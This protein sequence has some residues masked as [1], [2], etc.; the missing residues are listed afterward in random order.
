MNQRFW[1][2]VDKSDKSD[3]C[4]VWTGAPRTDGYGQFRLDGKIIRPHRFSYTVKFGA[5]PD[6]LFVCHSCDNRL[7]VNPDHLFLGTDSDNKADM[8]AK[9]RHV[10]GENHPNKKL[11]KEIV[12]AIR[13]KIA[14]GVPQ[15]KIA[16]MFQTQRSQV[17]L[18]NSGKRWASV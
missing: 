17:S 5:I 4:W 8:Y 10:F 9:K 16:E 7:C 2:K 18:I 11:S 12:L 14:E 15:R 6:G 3:E 13:K 1:S